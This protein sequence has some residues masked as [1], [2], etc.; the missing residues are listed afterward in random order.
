VALDQPSVQVQL[1]QV[2]VIAAD[3]GQDAICGP[4]DG[5]TDE[6]YGAVHRGPDAPV[7]LLVRLQ[8]AAVREAQ[9]FLVGPDLVGADGPDVADRAEPRCVEDA[10]AVPAQTHAPFAVLAVHEEARIESPISLE[11][12][13][14][15]QQKASSEPIHLDR[16]ILLP[17]SAQQRLGPA[18]RRNQL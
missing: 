3:E 7:Q 14:P 2:V 13:A 15:Q 12:L 9:P 17:V 10:T 16:A 8:A 1:T 5:V 6:L 11:D 4:A 18:A